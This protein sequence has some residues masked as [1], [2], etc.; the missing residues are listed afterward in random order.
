MT[1]SKL[2]THTTE[3]TTLALG[4][5]LKTLAQMQ[6]MGDSHWEYIT[7]FEQMYCH[8]LHLGQLQVPTKFVGVVIL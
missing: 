2:I 3:L 1:N 4:W 5:A 6:D 8:I 7:C